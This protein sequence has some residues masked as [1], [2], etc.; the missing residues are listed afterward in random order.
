MRQKG[1]VVAL[2]G[3]ARIRRSVA[4]PHMRS[5]GLFRVSVKKRFMRSQRLRNRACLRLVLEPSILRGNFRE[6][7]RAS[8]GLGAQPIGGQLND[9]SGPVDRVFKNFFCELDG[10]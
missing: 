9:I 4:V 1:T 10:H 2:V 3:S 5:R 8:C 7:W 6:W